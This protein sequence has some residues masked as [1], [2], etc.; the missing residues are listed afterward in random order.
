[1]FASGNYTGK[2]VLNYLTYLYW[3]DIGFKAT[4][5]IQF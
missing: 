3:I 5:Y 1:M 4:C 2:F